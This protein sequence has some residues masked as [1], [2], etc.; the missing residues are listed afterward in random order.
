MATNDASIDVRDWSLLGLLS[1]L[2]GGSFFFN[3]VILQ[4][5]PPFTLVFLRVTLA[6][7]V[8]L[9]LLLTYR[10]GFPKGSRGWLPFF[11]IGL[12]NNV[13]PF[14][15]IVIG[16]TYIP[17]GLA[18]ILNA[19][20][21]LF[22]IL[23]MALAG[24]EK[25]A[26]ASRCRDCRRPDWR[27]H[28]RRRWQQGGRVRRRSDHRH[29]AVPCR[30]LQLWALGAGGAA[31]VVEL[32]CARNG[33]IPD[34]GLDRDDDACRRNCRTPLAIADAGCGHMAR[35]DRSRCTLNLDQRKN[36]LCGANR[37]VDTQLLKDFCMLRVVHA[38]D[39]A[40]NFVTLL[41]HLGKSPGYL[42]HRP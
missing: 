17:G 21:P 2:W 29:P 13:L 14:S 30:R 26:C 19:T 33:D 38:R 22:T 41:R 9:P 32:A 3:G 20:T 1:I 40:A 4:E 23:V 18:S 10:I 5:L 7:I 34:A 11:A 28:S 25:I 36:R 6:S 35:R 8:L 24:E 42:R 12:F 16:Q 37:Q 39:G 15:L 31:P 27:D